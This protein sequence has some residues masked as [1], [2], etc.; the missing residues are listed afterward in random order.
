MRRRAARAAHRRGTARRRTPSQALGREDDAI[1]L[2]DEHGARVLRYGGLHVWD[3]DGDDLPSHLN[4]DGDELAILIED[5][6]ADYPLTIDPLMTS[7]AWTAESNQ[8][9]A[10]LVAPWRR[11]GT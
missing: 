2:F 3:A 5:D 9:E 7:P 6:G 8:D 10:S 4:L 1:D 11:R